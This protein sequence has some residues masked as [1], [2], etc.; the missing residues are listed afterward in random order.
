MILDIFNLVD[1]ELKISDK[2]F[3]VEEFMKL[4]DNILD[5]IFYS[6]SNSDNII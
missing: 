2:I 4:S 1:D 5:N 6:S 3:N